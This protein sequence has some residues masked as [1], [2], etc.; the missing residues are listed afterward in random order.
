[1][2]T[3]RGDKEV[4]QGTRHKLRLDLIPV[5]LIAE[6]GK[7]LTYGAA[8]YE[9]RN[10]EKGNDWDKYYAAALR[11]LYAWW[12]REEC[13]S[14]SKLSHLAHAITDL[15]FLLEYEV[16]MRS[17]DNRPKGAPWEPYLEIDCAEKL[18]PTPAYVSPYWSGMERLRQNVVS[19][20]N[21]STP[22]CEPP[23]DSIDR[24]MN[25]PSNSWFRRIL[26][27]LNFWS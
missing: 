9:D 23:S 1:V 4:T 12:S 26:G 2:T 17:C 3:Q 16:T 15:A 27:S 22:M 19:M 11:H 13:D 6:V 18:P 20:M 21:V 8:K 24:P 10:W 7:V 25:Y 14:E 5:R